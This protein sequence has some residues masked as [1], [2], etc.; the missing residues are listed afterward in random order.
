MFV[1]TVSE[2]ALFVQ[3]I[4]GW[5]VRASVNKVPPPSNPTAYPTREAAREFLMMRRPALAS[6]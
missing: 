2:T 6:Q 4:D 1:A 5:A 3:S